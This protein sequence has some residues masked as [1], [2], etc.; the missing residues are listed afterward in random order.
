MAKAA[1]NQN[2]GILFSPINMLAAKVRVRFM[3]MVWLE[4]GQGEVRGACAPPPKS[5]HLD[6]PPIAPPP[7]PPPMPPPPPPP[8]PP[9]GGPSA[10]FY[11]GGSRVQKRGDVT[12]VECEAVVVGHD[13][14]RVQVRVTQ[15]PQHTLGREMCIKRTNVVR[16]ERPTT[17]MAPW[18]HP[19]HKPQPVG[20]EPQNAPTHPRKGPS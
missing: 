17:N 14:F 3:V 4:G 16:V 19:H 10:H 13:G 12:P 9:P 20:T 11:W 1:M 5:P 6:P 7:N 18:P 15:G 8:P 2:W